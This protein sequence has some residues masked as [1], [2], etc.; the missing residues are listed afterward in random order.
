LAS[1]GGAAATAL[2]AANLPNHTH[3]ITDPG[4]LHS[5]HNTSFLNSGIPAGGNDT[6]STPGNTGTSTTGITNQNNGSNTAFSTISPYLGVN[7]IIKT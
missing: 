4:H 1:T 5:G 3:N 2:A 6:T 7:F